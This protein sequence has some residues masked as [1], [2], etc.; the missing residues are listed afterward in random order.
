MQK[1]GDCFEILW[2]FSERDSITSFPFFYGPFKAAF[3]ACAKYQ[4]YLALARF[5]VIV[6][7]KN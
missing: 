4:I 1:K 2:V 6:K 5:V 3:F 7:N